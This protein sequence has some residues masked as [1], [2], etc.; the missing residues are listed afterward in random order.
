MK[1][2]STVNW[3]E[4]EDFTF[5]MS[6]RAQ[7][8]WNLLWTQF[9]TGWLSN[10]IDDIQPPRPTASLDSLKMQPV[11]CVWFHS[12]YKLEKLTGLMWN[13]PQL[14]AVKLHVMKVQS[15]FFRNGT[16]CE[17]VCVCVCSWVHADQLSCFCGKKKVKQT[18]IIYT[19]LPHIHTCAM[20]VLKVIYG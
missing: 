18:L 5:L 2:W 14:R 1:L 17:C 7:A 3:L 12:S 4:N 13:L 11:L 6:S 15:N 19:N 9:D 8:C 16:L 20:L 10:C